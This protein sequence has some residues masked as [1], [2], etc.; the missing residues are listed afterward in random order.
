[1][2][3]LG[4]LHKRGPM[5]RRKLDSTKPLRRLCVQRA[6]TSAV[7]ILAAICLSQ[8]SANV[9][10][11]SQSPTEAEVTAAFIV[12]F[13]RFTDWPPQSFTDSAAPLTVGILGGEEVRVALDAFAG[14]KDLNGRKVIIRKIDSAADA[15]K[16]QVVFIVV[17]KGSVISD[18]LKG[19]RENGTLTIGQSEDILTRG[20]MIRLFLENAKMRFDVNVGATNLAKIHL[21][22]RLL[23]LARK[24]VDLPD[25]GAN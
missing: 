10:S 9:L 12:N 20:G 2:A 19:A 1:V 4:K 18:V 25:Q 21:S 24:I 23:A 6:L 3:F 16:C 15:R 5:Q 14:G 8:V 7:V 11:G 17:G 22:S 13:A